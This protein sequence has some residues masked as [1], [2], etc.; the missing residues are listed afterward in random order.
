[1]APGAFGYAIPIGRL[2]GIPLS[3]HWTLPALVVGLALHDMVRYSHQ[4]ALVQLAVGLIWGLSVLIHELGHATVAHRL[5]YRTQSIELHAFGGVAQIAGWMS[6]K[7]DILVSLS[8][9]FANFALYFVFS[10]LAS[11]LSGVPRAIAA[12]GAQFNLVLGF[13]N[14]LPTYPFDGGKALL[15]ALRVKMGPVKGDHLAYTIGLAIALPGLL[16]AVVTSS[17]LMALAFYIA[18]DA[19]RVQRARLDAAFGGTVVRPFPHADAKTG[20]TWLPD[21]LRGIFGR[22]RD[23]QPP[24][25]RVIKGGRFDEPPEKRSGRLN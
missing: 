12:G 9:P 14:L 15:S 22:A 20:G 23:A 8:G 10:G 24:K 7:H 17:P 4:A 2:R 25:L 13:F 16:F 21:W 11:Q 6:P 5:G 19:C 18:F 3:L 1:M